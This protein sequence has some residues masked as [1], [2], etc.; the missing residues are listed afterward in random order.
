MAVELL[1]KSWINRPMTEK[2]YGHLKSISNFSEFSPTLP[3]LC[4]ELDKSARELQFL[5]T[6]KP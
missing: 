4:L 6:G 3:L 1:R 2:E 5:H